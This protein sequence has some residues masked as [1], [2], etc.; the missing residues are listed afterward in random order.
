M[1]SLEY[2]FQSRISDYWHTIAEMKED[3]TNA[4]IPKNWKTEYVETHCTMELLVEREE[5]K[6]Q[7]I[8]VR[9]I[10][11]QLQRHMQGASDQS[12]QRNKVTRP[13]NVLQL[14]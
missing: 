7:R 3:E 13:G 11:T 6:S 9:P 8:W 10:F 2:G 1:E 12:D 4:S 14:L 5:E